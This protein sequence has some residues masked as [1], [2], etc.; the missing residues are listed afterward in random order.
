MTNK[1]ISKSQYTFEHY[2]KNP[3]V[4]EPYKGYYKKR[5]F[6]DHNHTTNINFDIPENVSNFIY[7]KF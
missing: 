5:L 2:G 7:G 6:K 3:V 1:T 4:L